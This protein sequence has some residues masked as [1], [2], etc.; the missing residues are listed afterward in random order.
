MKNKPNHL[1]VL[2]GLLFAALFLTLSLRNDPRPRDVP[3]DVS[4]MFLKLQTAS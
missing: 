1:I 2:W 4:A 3:A